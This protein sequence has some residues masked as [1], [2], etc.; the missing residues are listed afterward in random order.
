MN[1]SRLQLWPLYIGAA[2]VPIVWSRLL[3]DNYTEAKWLALRL[4]ASISLIWLALRKQPIQLPSLSVVQ[5]SFLG[6]WAMFSILNPI[7]QQT[8]FWSTVVWLDRAA[9]VAIIVTSFQVGSSRE[10]FRNLRWPI[11][12]AAVFVCTIS[13]VQFVLYRIIEYQPS[14]RFFAG[15]FGENNMCAQFLVLALP[16]AVFCETPNYQKYWRWISTVVSAYIL[17]FIFLH[18]SR[19]ALIGAGLVIVYFAVTGTRREFVRIVAVSGAA[20]LLSAVLGASQ[21]TGFKISDKS[22]SNSDRMELYLETLAMIR[23]IP[24][25][26]GTGRYEFD[27]IPFLNGGQFSAGEGMIY[28][29]PHSEPLRFLSEEGILWSVVSIFAMSFIF[30]RK[31]VGIRMVSSM[32]S[33]RFKP[34]VGLALA[35]VPEILFQ[36]PLQNAVPSLFFGILVSRLFDRSARKEESQFCG[37]SILFL[38]SIGIFYFTAASAYANYKAT[39][40]RGPLDYTESCKLDDSNWYICTRAAQFLIESGDS[41]VAKTMM[42]EEIKKRPFNFVALRN[43]GMASWRDG[44]RVLACEFFQREQAL[45]R[46]GNSNRDFV[47]ENC[48]SNM[49]HELKATSPK[50]LYKSHLQ[51]A[52]D[53]K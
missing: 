45:L 32:T 34:G 3:N 9:F 1:W 29:S 18:Q 27:S 16:F 42:K 36:F 19:S 44:D 35:F 31:L 39:N 38:V 8:H 7:I 22:S 11:S 17:M 40:A 13:L 47:S 20:L 21:Q 6:F 14:P 15:T 5:V 4:T 50:E 48:D 23:S 25:G 37:R 41:A 43:L 49:L 12:F 2:I 46:A 28:K 33:N 53:L 30:L 26:V 52:R 51:W 10:L 24:L